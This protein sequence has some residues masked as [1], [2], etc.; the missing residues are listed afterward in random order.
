MS[1]QKHVTD[2][3]MSNKT[4]KSVKFKVQAKRT[5]WYVTC[6][7]LEKAIDRARTMWEFKDQELVFTKI[8]LETEI[9]SVDI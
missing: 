2:K 8:T 7:T 4:K 9:L 1:L 5:K 3:K 6:D